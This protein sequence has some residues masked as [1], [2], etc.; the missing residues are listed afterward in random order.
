[1]IRLKASWYV[2]G[3]AIFF[4]RPTEYSLVL[5]DFISGGACDEE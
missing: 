4:A 1:M 5:P 2:C 3:G